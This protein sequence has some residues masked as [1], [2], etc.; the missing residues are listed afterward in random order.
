M[1]RTSGTDIQVEV[2]PLDIEVFEDFASAMRA[3]YPEWSGALWR[4]ETIARLI[5]LFPEGQLGVLVNGKLAGCALSIIVDIDK[6]G[7]DHTYNAITGNYTFSTHDPQ[8]TVLYGIEVFI[9]PDHRG[10]RLG[11]RLSGGVP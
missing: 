11:R 10:M 9:H 4:K 6:I 1:T 3:A 5:E 7:L 8:G 2:R